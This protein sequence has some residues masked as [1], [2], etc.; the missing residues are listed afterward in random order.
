MQHYPRGHWRQTGNQNKL[1]APLRIQVWLGTEVDEELPM[2]QRPDHMPS[3]FGDG[4]EV[5]RY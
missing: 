4:L 1:S 5:Q 2:Q 3:L